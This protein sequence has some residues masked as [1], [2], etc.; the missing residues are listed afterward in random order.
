MHTSNVPTEVSI[1]Q[2]LKAQQYILLFYTQVFPLLFYRLRV[3]PVAQK[4]YYIAVL[5]CH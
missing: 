2:I 4:P 5:N 1:V 3:C